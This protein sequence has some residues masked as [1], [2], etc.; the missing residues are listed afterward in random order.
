MTTKEHI[1]I[2]PTR[3][4]IQFDI[5]QGNQS[6]WF[7]VDTEIA[8]EMYQKL[9]SVL[10]EQDDWVEREMQAFLFKK[11]LEKDYPVERFIDSDHYKTECQHAPKIVRE[12]LQQ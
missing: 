4:N 7:S 11:R 12:D 5:K 1:T 8:K 2:T 9:G 6:R 3:N 10:N